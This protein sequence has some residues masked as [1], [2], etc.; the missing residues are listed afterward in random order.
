M[1]LR[2]SLKKAKCIYSNSMRLFSQIGKIDS[3]VNYYEILGFK[4]IDK[5]E[6]IT[7]SQIKRN[8]YK[9]AKK[10]HPD[11]ANDS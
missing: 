10:Y 5:H 1:N 11:A 4:S 8:F 9:L 7:D 3:S 2:Q 6:S